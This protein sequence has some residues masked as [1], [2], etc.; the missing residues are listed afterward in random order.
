MVLPDSHE[1]SRASWYSGAALEN[2]TFRLQGYHLL[3]RIFPDTSP[4]PG[5]FDS[6][7]TPQRAPSSPTTPFIQR[8]RAITYDWFGL[9]PLRSPLLG[10]S[11]LLSTPEGT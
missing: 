11:L 1:I 5:F 7:S 4:M 6:M 9:L 3:W 8:L 2:Q 10:E